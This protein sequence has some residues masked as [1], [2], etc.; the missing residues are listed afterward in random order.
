MASLF[1]V[2]ILQ[3][4]GRFYSLE[5]I[6]IQHLN[7]SGMQAVWLLL[8]AVSSLVRRKKRSIED[9]DD[10]LMEKIFRFD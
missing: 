7:I 3:F 6:F 2:G 1:G 9:F 5:P 10:L 4:I 8:M